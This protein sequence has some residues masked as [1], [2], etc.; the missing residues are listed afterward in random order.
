MPGKKKKRAKSAYN[1]R[2]MKRPKSS[3]PMAETVAKYSNPGDRPHHNAV[4]KVA[5]SLINTRLSSTNPALL[6]ALNPGGKQSAF[7]KNLNKP[8]IKNQIQNDL[9]DI[10]MQLIDQERLI[11]QSKINL[12]H[13]ADF[14]TF[15]MFRVFDNMGRGSIT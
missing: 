5:R 1:P 14:N 10:F 11:E 9:L 6:K 8:M 3:N 12:A 7:M 2:G 4:Q 15:D 13:H